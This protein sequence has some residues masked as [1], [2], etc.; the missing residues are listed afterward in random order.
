MQKLNL[1]VPLPSCTVDKK[2]INQLESFLLNNIPRLL[3]KA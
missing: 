1:R 3:K 2:L